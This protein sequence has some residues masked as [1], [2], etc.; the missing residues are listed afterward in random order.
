MQHILQRFVLPDA[1][2][3]GF[4]ICLVFFTGILILELIS[5]ESWGIVAR[6]A[7][8]PAKFWIVLNCQAALGA[9]FVAV[10]YLFTH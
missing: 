9:V 7:D 3:S 4:V 6:K 10:I 8:Q 5:G 2:T 1:R